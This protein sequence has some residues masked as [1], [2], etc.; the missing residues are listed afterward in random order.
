MSMRLGEAPGGGNRWL[1]PLKWGIAN[2]FGRVRILSE[3]F[4]YFLYELLFP[5]PFRNIFEK[6]HPDVA[7]VPNLHD[8]FDQEMSREA[9]LQHVERIG[10]VLNWDHY[11]KYYLAFVPENLLAQSEQMRYFAHRYQ[12][13]KNK[14]IEI[15]GYPFLDHVVDPSHAIPRDKVLEDLGF[16]KDAQYILYVAGSMY[17]PD[18]PDIIEEMIK[19]ADNKEIGENVHFVIRPYPGGR[20]KDDEFDQKKF[21]GFA[22]HPRVSFQ[23]QKFWAGFETNVAFMNIVRYAG[24]VL[25]VYSTAV[26]PAVALDRPTM[27][28]MFDGYK[29]RPFHRSIK[30]FALREHYRDALE[31]GGQAQ[32]VDFEDLKKK[33]KTFLAHPETDKDKR[34]VMRPRVLGPLDGKGSER[35]YQALARRLYG[36]NT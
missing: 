12:G 28:F 18:E 9:K 6:Y 26:L 13:K 21:E 35:I 19:W 24:V 22:N 3:P 33:L 10:M 36:S 4:V 7:F 31:T 1:A 8:R 15:V 16:P 5:R 17:S 27:T 29:K 11:D 32:A 2:T 25:A 34:D 30:R 20:G 23:M 14:N